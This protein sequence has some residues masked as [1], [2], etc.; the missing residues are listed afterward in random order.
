M[1]SSQQDRIDHFERALAR[2]LRR[3]KKDAMQNNPPKPNQ[4]APY[5]K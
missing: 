5:G 4:E 1:N 3:I 2:I